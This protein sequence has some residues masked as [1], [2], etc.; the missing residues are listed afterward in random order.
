MSTETIEQVVTAYFTHMGAMNP[1]GWVE[2]FAEDALIYDPVGKPP[3]KAH[4][5]FQK[6]FGL[7][8]KFYEKL[9]I[10]QD[11]IFIAGNGAAV[12]WTMRVL[13]KNGRQ[14]STEGISTFEVN[15]AGK[16]QTMHSYW[17]EA[18]MMAQL[19]E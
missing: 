4:Q 10:S 2:N 7:L 18:E 3:M 6:F 13:A 8:A 5:D 14:G 12:K 16:I 9:E 1:E 17:N 15:E 19:K 11:H